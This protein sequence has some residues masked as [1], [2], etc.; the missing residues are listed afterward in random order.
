MRIIHHESSF[1]L[2]MP[3]LYLPSFTLPV[4]GPALIIWAEEVGTIL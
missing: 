3:Y 2:Y 1:S 4:L